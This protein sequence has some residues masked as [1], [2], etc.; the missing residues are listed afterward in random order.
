MTKDELVSY[1]RSIPVDAEIFIE[2]PN[3]YGKEVLYHLD[4][5]SGYMFNR[6]WHYKQ[7]IVLLFKKADPVEKKD[8]Y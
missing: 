7:R 1:L 5:V 4:K 8:G 2:K 3:Q 6:E